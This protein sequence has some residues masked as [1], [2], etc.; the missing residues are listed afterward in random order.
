[1]IEIKNIPL[2]QYVNRL[3]NNEYFSF[4][5]YGDGE[6]I[7]LFRGAGWVSCRM[8]SVSKEIQADMLQSLIAHVSAPR[9]IF[10]L[11]HY[12]VRRFEKHIGRFLHRHKLKNISWVEADVFH[13]ASLRGLLFP[14]IEQLRQ[15]KVVIVGPNFL[16]KMKE[17]IFNYSAF[18]E[19]PLRNCYAHQESIKSNILS[20]HERFRE[21]VVYSF[22]CGPVAETLILKLQDEMPENFLI[23]FG[24]VWDV[25]CGKRS[26]RYT[27]SR[28]YTDDILRTNKARLKNAT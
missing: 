28:K 1:M 7:A 6:W 5:R 24:S 27:K 4:V 20:I 26:R 2:S 19:V 23:D 3:K 15:M 12:A 11:Q 13:Y 8:Q 10:G 9:L 16:Y 17:G 22:C 14:L 25:F 18:V 21:N